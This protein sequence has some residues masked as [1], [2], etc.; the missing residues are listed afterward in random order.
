M[1][2]DQIRALLAGPFKSWTTGVQI[3]TAL[4]ARAVTLGE[5]PVATVTQAIQTLQRSGELEINGK[6][7]RA[8]RRLA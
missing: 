5:N 7:I 2:E 3:Q 1:I 8:A 6:F 4:E